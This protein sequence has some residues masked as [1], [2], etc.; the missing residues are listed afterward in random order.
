MVSSDSITI[1]SELPMF[2]SD[3]NNPFL[4]Q[5]KGNVQVSMGNDVRTHVWNKHCLLC[6]VFVFFFVSF[7][8][9]S[10]IEHSLGPT[11]VCC[12]NLVIRIKSPCILS[13]P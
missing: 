11:A 8:L 7:Q 9:V 1:V 10:S 3:G 12:L 2:V 5:C 6:L 4:F 13:A